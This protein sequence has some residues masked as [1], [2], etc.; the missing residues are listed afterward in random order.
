MLISTKFPLLTAF[1]A[2]FMLVSVSGF[3]AYAA[4]EDE[5]DFSMSVPGV[6]MLTLDRRSLEFS[7][8]GPE[9]EAGFSEHK[10]V[11]ASVS[12]NAEWLLVI[13]GTSETWQ[14]PWAKPVGDIQWRYGGGQYAALSRNEASVVSGG[15]QNQRSYPVHFRIKLGWE[16]DVPGDYRY[17]FVLFQ[18]TTP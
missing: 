13:S 16:N 3:I 2:A 4:P 8:G 17:E 6:R 10:V 11:V 15:A 12:A 14:G 1:L 9:F 18:L 5:G 7:P